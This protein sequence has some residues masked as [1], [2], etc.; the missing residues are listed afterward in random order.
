MVIPPT[1]P[2]AAPATRLPYVTNPNQVAIAVVVASKLFKV[3]RNS[4]VLDVDGIGFMAT[5]GRHHG[6]GRKT[7][8]FKK[9][10]KPSSRACHGYLV[11][12]DGEYA[13]LQSG[14]L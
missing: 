6:D 10:R 7:I 9:R 2:P 12:G 13:R 8:H 4:S 11:V 5:N 3:Y 14:L 1:I